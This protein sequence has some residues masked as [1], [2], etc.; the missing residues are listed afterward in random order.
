MQN[1]KS[2]LRPAPRVSVIVPVYNGATFIETCLDSLLAQT[3]ADLEILVVDDGSTDSTPAIL[4]CYASCHANIRVFSQRNAGVSAA[5]N[6]GLAHA[7]GEFI[8][9]VDADDA[10]APTM[11]AELLQFAESGR[12]DVAICNAWL[13]AEGEPARLAI[14][15]VPNVGVQLGTAWLEQQVAQRTLKHYIWCHLYRNEFLRAQ[16]TRF[17]PGLVHQDIVWTNLVM[18]SAQRVAFL[19]RPLYHYHQRTGSLSK[20]RGSAKRLAAARHYL[21]VVMLLDGLAAR[22]SL[23]SSARAAVR[24]QAA[25]EG[26]GLFHIARKLDRA[27]R[28]ALFAELQEF[29]FTRLLWRNAQ[30]FAQAR[31]AAARGA[32]LHLD[33]LGRR[34]REQ[35]TGFDRHTQLGKVPSQF[36]MD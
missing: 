13:I 2:F 25:D 17:V 32:W 28:A 1:N 20:P 33:T 24:F 26:L 7:R 16:H 35:F 31:R 5:R 4:Q 11:Y 10:V 30:T 19:D 21:R 36:G 6:L 22:T 18:L 34:L 27:D 3:L 23:T 8:A 15:S 14:A 29:R 9:F 12:L